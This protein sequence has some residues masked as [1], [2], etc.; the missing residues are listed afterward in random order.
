MRDWWNESWNIA[1]G[2]T[3]VSP[4]CANCWAEKMARRLK[5]MGLTEYQDVVGGAASKWTGQVELAR[6]RLGDPLRWRKPRV[7]A[8]N[9]MGDLFHKN[10]PFAFLADVFEVM[11]QANGHTFLI[12]TKRAGRML[13]FV[14]RYE[15]PSEKFGHVWLGT[16]VGTQ[17][18]AD[19]SRDDM[20]ALARMGWQT[21]VSSEPRLEAVDWSGWEFLDWLATGGESGPQARPMHPDWVR[22]DRDW[23]AAQGIRFMFKQWGEWVP[24]DHMPWVTDRTRLKYRPVSMDGV[25]MCRVGRGLAGHVLDGIEHRWSPGSL[26]TSRQERAGHSTSRSGQR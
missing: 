2:C 3:K 21:W 11:R 24:L 17:G 5:A 20:A 14:N 22:A 16:S 18:T 13:E 10:V 9:L 23:C 12:L 8:V 26:D 15:L 4:E 7:V 19:K 6:S 25:T 1:P